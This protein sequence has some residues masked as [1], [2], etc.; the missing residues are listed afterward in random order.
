PVVPGDWVLVADAV[1]VAVLPRTSLL[2]RR[3]PTTE[4]EQLLA[5][6]VDVVAVVCG[7]DRPVRH[8]R[9]A[10]TAAMAWDAGATPLVVLTKTDLVDDADAIAERVEAENP[11]VDVLTLSAPEGQ[12]L[13]DLAAHVRDRTVVLVGE[14]GAGKSTL[15]NA[16]A[17]TDV[18]A[19]GEVRA[20]DAKGRHTTTTR[21]LHLLA[22]GGVLVDSPGIRA[23]G[24]VS[25]ADAV[26]ATF[27]DVE[28]LAEMC[29]FTDCGHTNEP[30]CAV[31]DAIRSGQLDPARLASWRALRREAEAA[32]VRADAV[33]RRRRGKQFSKM[34]REVK[35]HKGR[36]PD[37]RP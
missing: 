6:N 31:T 11:G 34:V 16:L 18:A 27:A 10:R 3:D 24:L 19:V 22:S 9:I 4:A 36:P 32:A 12:G 15:T 2:R 25:D 14:S 26:A 17:G 33:E 37:E 13:D 28:D 5:A 35:E 21:E 20:G 8:G 7:L 1:V 29:R 23:V 30:G